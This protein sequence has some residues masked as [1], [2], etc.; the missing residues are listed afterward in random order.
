MA[1]PRHLQHSTRSVPIRGSL[2]SP[3]VIGLRCSR[4]GAYHALRGPRTTV[5]SSAECDI[6]ISDEFVSSCHFLLERCGK[7]TLLRDSGSKNGTS[8][9]GC[10]VRVA[11]LA[12]GQRI[13]LGNTT[14]TVQ[15]EEM[16]TS[17]RAIDVL[18]G[19]DPAFRRAVEL[20]ARAARVDQ[21]VLLLGETGTGKELF[22]RPDPR[23]VAPLEERLRSSKL[24]RYRP[25]PH[26]L[27]TLWLRQ[28]RVYRRG[29]G[30]A[31]GLRRSSRRH[32]F[33]RRNRRAPRPNPTCPPP[34]PR[35]RLHPTGGCRA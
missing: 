28:G 1:V 35:D 20:A 15:A 18:V 11:E 13:T 25:Q 12:A 30:S 17:S 32:P 21:P 19:S 3:A 16:A 10:P 22:A 31:G 5:G 27:G 29:W 14:L 34:R 6:Q 26:L 8:I 4:S 7:R 24:R 2:P 33:P 9:D 23:G